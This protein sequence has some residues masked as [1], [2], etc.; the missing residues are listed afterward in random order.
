VN[1]TLLAPVKALVN[2]AAALVGLQVVRRRV[3]AA[4]AP[5]RQRPVVNAYHRGRCFKCFLGDI[6]C[7]YILRGLGWDNQL[8]DI[9]A[10]LPRTAGRHVIEVGANIGGSLVPRAAE[11]AELTFHCIEPVPAFFELLQQ[12][13]ESF[14]APNVRLYNHA[15]T[16]HDGETVEIH[17]Q[18]GTAGA[19]AAYDGHEAMGAVRVQGISLDSFC[20][21]LDVALIKIDT[22]GFEQVV[23][24]GGESLLR[25]QRPPIFMEFHVALMR[26]AGRDPAEVA[27]L[28][29]RVGYRRLRIW[30]NFGTHLTDT[31]SFA[32]LLELANAAQYYVDVLLEAA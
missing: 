7:E 17:T 28:L 24:E 27:A 2:G 23:L 26:A 21:D 19:V 25:R 11:H 12:N 3:D 20:R 31:T 5:P 32:A 14:G 22:D 8:D 9:L 30:D 4:P 16:A 13:A 15:V 29:Q 18:L 1:T 10:S 6:Q